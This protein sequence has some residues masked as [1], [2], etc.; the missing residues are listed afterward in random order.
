MKTYTLPVL[1]LFFILLAGPSF[2]QKKFELNDI[3]KLTSISDPQISPDGKSVV[4]IV[5]RPDYEAN[6]FNTELVWVDIA[7]GKSRP[8]TFDR[9]GVT[10]PRWSPDGTRLSFLSRIATGK[11]V[12][13]QLFV[14]HMSGGDARQIT[15]AP[16]G[17]QHYAWSPDG[18]SFAYVTADEVANK[19]LLEKGYDAFEVGN[20]DMFVS[21]TRQPAHIW[22]VAAQGG[23]AKRLTSGTWTLPITIPPGSPSSP[24]TF[25][26]DGKTIAFVKVATT[27][28]GDNPYRSIQLLNV[29]DGTFKPL[30]K[31]DQFEGFPQFSPDGTKVSYLYVHEGRPGDINEV[32]LTATTGGEGKNMT[33]PIDR[34][35]YRALWMPD[36]KNLL[37][38]GHDDNRT[39]L[40]LQPLEGPARKLN[41]GSVSPNW[42]F[43]VDMNVG[44]NGSIAFIGT[45]PLTPAELYIMTNA[46]T[47]PR[48]L[49]DFNAEVRAMKLGKTETVRWEQEGFKHSGILT[50][51][52]NYEAG[53]KYP[54][55]LIVHG[56]PNAASI[57]TFA[58]RSQ[59]FAT[60]GYFVFEPN[61]RGS[62]N[63][64]SKYKASIIGDAGAGPGRDV[65]AGVKLLVRSGMI[66]STRMAVTGWSYG[67]YMTTWLA[68]NYPVWK[69]AV[70]GAA[71]T[72]WVDQ[73]NLSDGNVA[74]GRGFGGSPYTGKMDAY[75]EQSP[76]TYASKI[77]APT[78][79]LANT[80]DPRVPVTQS[81][82]LY[83]ALKDNGV[84][85]RF[86]AWPIPFHNAT[87][88][89]RG[90]EVTR[91]W[92]GWVNEYLMDQK[93]TTT[94]MN[95]N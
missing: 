48:R 62:D 10:Q 32:W 52:S 19:E 61:Y 30:T 76:I 6:R 24:L 44:K 68:A 86:I 43:W 66:D 49:T 71:V 80:E 28:S 17:V 41:L 38:G 69:A 15:K 42:S 29:A 54:M 9:T 18:N 55:V 58:P 5:S 31:R 13:P 1:L 51:P 73:Y 12:M 14:F 27:Y 67:G 72:D 85:T 93:M 2:S 70:A 16:R 64:G 33:D 47:P 11:E 20:N 95:K 21:A 36:G 53:K 56:G 25:T 50:F 45:D 22:M 92:M 37:V 26:P 39:S 34:D 57:E 40:W 46:N 77:K 75:L 60:D 79:V 90:R 83:H 82:K 91:F 81:Y 35:I 88:P 59:L 84:T 87:D 94:I 89:V 4:V 78:L 8:I 65:M 63:M 7:T 23:E 3:G 74:R